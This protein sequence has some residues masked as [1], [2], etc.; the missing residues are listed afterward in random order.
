M[1]KWDTKGWKDILAQKDAEIDRLKETNET[2]IRN[3]IEDA[4]REHRKDELISELADW[5]DKVNKEWDVT[6]LGLDPDLS[7]RAREATR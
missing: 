4:D 6:D 1:S 5:M 7:K 2:L 3:A